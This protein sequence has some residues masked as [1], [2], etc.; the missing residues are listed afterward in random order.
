MYFRFLST[1]RQ[2]G[3]LVYCMTMLMSLDWCFGTR[4]GEVSWDYY[5]WSPCSMVRRYSW[6]IWESLLDHYSCSLHPCKRSHM[7]TASQIGKA[8]RQPF[9]SL[10]LETKCALGISVKQSTKRVLIKPFIHSI[11]KIQIQHSIILYTSFDKSVKSND[12]GRTKTISYQTLCKH[13]WPPSNHSA[14][15][16]NEEVNNL[17]FP[18]DLHILFE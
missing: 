4:Q 16:V 9:L 7:C 10:G 13:R 5:C 6:W 1:R 11:R 15:K 8:S 18:I 14:L 2:R 12:K 17:I 3:K